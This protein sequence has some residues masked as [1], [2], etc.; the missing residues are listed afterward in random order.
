MLLFAL[1]FASTAVVAADVDG[2]PEASVVFPASWP[3]G[4]PSGTMIAEGR[5]TVG[6]GEGLA[7]AELLFLRGPRFVARLFT[8][9]NGR[10]KAYDAV[11]G[12]EALQAW[13]HAPGVA[14]EHLVPEVDAVIGWHGW[15][16]TEE[17]GAVPCR[18]APLTPLAER[19]FEGACLESSP[20]DLLGLPLALVLKP[21]TTR[22]P[23]V[24]AA[25]PPG[26]DPYLGA[27]SIYLDEQ[28]GQARVV[29]IHRVL[30]CMGRADC[31]AL[32]ARVLAEV[33]G[34]L[35][36]PAKTRAGSSRILIVTLTR[37]Q[38]PRTRQWRWALDGQREVLLLQVR[39]PRHDPGK[40]EVVVRYVPAEEAP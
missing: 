37:G 31:R 30:H 13:V 40:V 38:R 14:F 23:S 35:G 5:L 32:G 25:A 24:V 7:G 8:D 18:F 17:R 1:A 29:A 39:H 22:Y 16:G 10:F 11:G 21:S 33:S 27:F 19:F 34:M 4:Q 9:A 15:G 36:E 28:D 2:Q 20:A 12:E 3:R 26:E 6:G